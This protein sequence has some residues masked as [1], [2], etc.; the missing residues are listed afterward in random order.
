[1]RWHNFLAVIEP[2]LTGIIVGCFDF[3]NCRRAIWER[4]KVVQIREHPR[5]IWMLENTFAFVDLQSSLFFKDPRYQVFEKIAYLNGNPV[6]LIVCGDYAELI[7]VE[8]PGCSEWRNP[9]NSRS[10][11]AANPLPTIFKP[12]FARQAFGIDQY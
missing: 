12:L 1:M 10:V 4:H 7:V 9:E 8:I 2:A 11:T 3:K 6:S 5:I